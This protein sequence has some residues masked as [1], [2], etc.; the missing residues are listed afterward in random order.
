MIRCSACGC[1]ESGLTLGTCPN[2]GYIM[3]GF[4]R[5]SKRCAVERTQDGSCSQL[6]RNRLPLSLP[7]RI[8]MLRRKL[9]LLWIDLPSEC[10]ARS[11]ESRT[12][13]PIWRQ[14]QRDRHLK[15]RCACMVR[16]RVV[17]SRKGAPPA[18]TAI[19]RPVTYSGAHH[20]MCVAKSKH[21]E[22]GTSANLLPN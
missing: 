1:D 14:L 19:L 2:G 11:I 5:L 6:S 13:R 4:G 10:C 17:D 8:V 9:G 15:H 16:V 18:N 21:R 3:F 7:P 20:I 12:N 22:T